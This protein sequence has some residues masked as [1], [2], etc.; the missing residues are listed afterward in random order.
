MRIASFGVLIAAALLATACSRSRAESTQPLSTSESNHSRL[1]AAEAIELAIQEARRLGRELERYESP[2]VGFSWHGSEATW[3]VNF[4]GRDP[5]PGNHF[6]VDI[7]DRDGS[8]RLHA[9]R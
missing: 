2:A 4:Q 6:S 3:H 1:S 9:G 8:A 5:V 7:E